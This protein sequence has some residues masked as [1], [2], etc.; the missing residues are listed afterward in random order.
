MELIALA[1]ACATAMLSLAL[2]AYGLP[3]WTTDVQLVAAAKFF[4]IIAIL[5]TLMQLYQI[6]ISHS[7]P[8]NAMDWISTGA[9][10]ILGIGFFMKSSTKV[11]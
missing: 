2:L 1:Q 11:S 10:V 4:G 5:F 9:T 3:N 7:A 8:G 6:L